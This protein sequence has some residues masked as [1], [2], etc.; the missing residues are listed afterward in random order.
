[1]CGEH[2][3][4]VLPLGGPVVAGDQAHAVQATKVAEHEGIAGLR[5]VRCAIGERKVP[6]RVLRPTM[7]LEKR[8]LLGRPWLDVSPPAAH[9][10]LT[11]VDQ[12]PSLGDSPLFAKYL[13]TYSVCPRVVPGERGRG[14]DRE[15]GR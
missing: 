12:V 6:G 11:G 5:L 3:L 15:Q 1:V 13:A 7:S 10:E 14:R 4:G 8:V 2:D 9:P